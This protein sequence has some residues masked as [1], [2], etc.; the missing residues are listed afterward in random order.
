MKQFATFSCSYGCSLVFAVQTVYA[1]NLLDKHFVCLNSV[2]NFRLVF[3]NQLCGC[4]LNCFVESIE[5]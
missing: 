2:N 5:N 3:L 1:K 4:I